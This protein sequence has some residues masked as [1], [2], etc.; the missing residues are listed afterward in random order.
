MFVWTSA[1]YNE[2]YPEKQQN[3]IRNKSQKLSANNIFYSLLDLANI[4]YSHENL[5][6]SFA[7]ETFTSDKRSLLTINN[8]V[9]DYDSLKAEAMITRSYVLQGHERR[10]F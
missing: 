5:A 4:T 1:L 6:K 8:E 3:L 9:I 10:K 7:S 2:V